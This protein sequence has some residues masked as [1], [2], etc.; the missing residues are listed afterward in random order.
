MKEDPARQDRRNW[1]HAPAHFDG[2]SLVINGCRVM[3]D[4]EQPYMQRLAAVATAKGGDILEL[5]Y[6]L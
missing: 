4:W 6:G 3:E 2:R 5:G 1:R